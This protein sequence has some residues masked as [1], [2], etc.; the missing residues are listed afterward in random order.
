MTWAGALSGYGVGSATSYFGVDQGTPI[1][2]HVDGGT[3]TTL[4]TALTTVANHALITDCA[5]AQSI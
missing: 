5:I 4:A 1:D 3:S 2:A